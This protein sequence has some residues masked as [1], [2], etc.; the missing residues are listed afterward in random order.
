MYAYMHP[1]FEGVSMHACILCGCV[2]VACMHAVCGMPVYTVCKHPAYIHA[3]R[4]RVFVAK[5]SNHIECKIIL[6]YIL[7]KV[8]SG[9][10]HII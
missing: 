10:F 5:L 9:K 4:G 7:L 3:G 8:K 2:G 1:S 6:I